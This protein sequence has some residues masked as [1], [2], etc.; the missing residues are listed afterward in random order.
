MITTAHTPVSERSEFRDMLLEAI[1]LAEVVPVDGP[2]F[3]FLL[4]PWLFLVLM[5]AGPFACLVV[6][7][8]AMI[9]AVAAVAAVVAAIV[10]IVVA[11][12]LL[13]GRVHRSLK[14]RRST[15]GA[16][17]ARVVAMGSPRVAA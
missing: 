10:G 7:V 13:A 6:I 5:L 11:P 9:V 16:P 14:R 17:A 4:A 15:G 8:V 2:P 12:Y 1:P 3:V